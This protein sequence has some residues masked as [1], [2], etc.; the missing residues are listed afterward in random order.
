MLYGLRFDNEEES[1]FM[2]EWDTG[3]MAI[4]RRRD[5]TQ[6][7]FAKK[8]ATYLQANCEERRVRDLGL[9]NF[10]VTT[11]TSTPARLE[12]MLEIVN[13]MTDSRGT[14]LFLFTDGRVL[15]GN[16]PLEVRWWTGKGKLVRLKD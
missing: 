4:E 15:A 5:L 16:N 3:E 7:H 13:A 8:I 10:R 14:N 2:L 9:P 6:T 12:K 11:V 1:Y